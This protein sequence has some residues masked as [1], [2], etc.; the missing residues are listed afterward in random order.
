MLSLMA[1]LHSTFCKSLQ[2]GPSNRNI[3]ANRMIT[4]PQSMAGP[5]RTR[6]IQQSL[7][8]FKGHG[9]KGFG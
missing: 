7:R 1:A 2:T 8:C 9:S 5:A 6:S 4:G 3:N